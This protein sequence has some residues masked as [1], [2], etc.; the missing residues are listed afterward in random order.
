MAGTK[1]EFENRD[2]DEGSDLSGIPLAG[3]LGEL[4]EDLSN[5]RGDL[6]TYALRAAENMSPDMA[7]AQRG[8]VDAAETGVGSPK[9]DYSVRSIYDSR[10]INSR[11]FNLWFTAVGDDASAVQI[12]V[13]RNCFIVPAGYVAVLRG[14]TILVGPPLIP[15]FTNYDGVLR[16]AVNGA[17]VDP[18]D[19]TVGP[20]FGAP[21]SVLSQLEIPFQTN[22]EVETFVLADEAQTVGVFLDIGTASPEADNLQVGFRGAFLLKTGVPAQFQAANEAGRARVA[23]TSSNADFRNIASAEGVTITKRKRVPFP[24]VPILRR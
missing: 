14:V 2:R 9:I 19:V 7:S 16:I 5:E 23:V 17:I 12:E 20:E 18:P 1:G 6:N 13:F 11:E 24:N 8:R 22:Q 10:P 21:A 4:P 15:D 3:S